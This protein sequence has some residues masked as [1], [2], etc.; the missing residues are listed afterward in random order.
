MSFI[1]ENSDENDIILFDAFYTQRTFDY[2]YKGKLERIGLPADTT[3]EN[4]YFFMNLNQTKL[5]KKQGIWLILS[6]TSYRNKD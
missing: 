3:E 1:E 4:I 2:Y 5:L 6:H